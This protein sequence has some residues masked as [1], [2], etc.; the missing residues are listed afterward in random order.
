MPPSTLEV[1]IRP[2]SSEQ[3]IPEFFEI[4][5]ILHCSLLNRQIDPFSAH[6]RSQLFVFLFEVR[7]LLGL[8][9]LNLRL[10]GLQSLLLGVEYCTRPIIA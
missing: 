8:F 9:L 1:N 3:E 6:L 10:D 2:F 5:G 7:I 4:L